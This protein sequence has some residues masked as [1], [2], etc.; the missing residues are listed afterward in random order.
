MMQG[1]PFSGK[2]TISVRLD[3]DGNAATRGAGDMTGEYRKNPVEIGAK[4]VDI[5]IDQLTK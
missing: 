2:I 5:V 3:K 4:N 1:T